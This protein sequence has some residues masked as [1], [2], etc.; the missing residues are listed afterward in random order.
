MQGFATL[1]Y[2]HVLTW[3]HTTRTAVCAPIAITVEVLD[4]IVGLSP[5]GRPFRPI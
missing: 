5:T 3:Y 2:H 1:F 4:H